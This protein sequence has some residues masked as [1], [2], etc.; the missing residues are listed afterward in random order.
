MKLSNIA[1]T[2]LLIFTPFAAF[3]DVV[4]WVDENGRIHFGDKVPDKYQAQSET[5]DIQDT[6]FI[7]ND[8]TDANDQQFSKMRTRQKNQE[9]N[10]IQTAQWEIQQKEKQQQTIESIPEK[11][12]PMNNT[13][14]E[15]LK[16]GVHPVQRKRRSGY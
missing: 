5:L 6:N 15:L 3:A 14:M 9:L 8:N 11:I 10:R 7:K 1:L 12:G 16:M 13:A 2:A 4:K